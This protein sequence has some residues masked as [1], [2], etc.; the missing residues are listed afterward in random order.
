MNVSG[1]E[2]SDKCQLHCQSPAELLHNTMHLCVHTHTHTHTHTPSHTY[3]Y[4][5]TNINLHAQEHT[6]THPH[7]LNIPAL[8]RPPS[9]TLLFLQKTA[10]ISL[11]GLSACA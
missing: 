3:T 6:H 7:T 5:H 2:L 8:S 4:T 11:S 1:S 9:G 10:F